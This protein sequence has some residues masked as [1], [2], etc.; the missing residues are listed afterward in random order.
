MLKLQSTIGRAVFAVLAAFAVL[1][2]GCGRALPPSSFA[3]EGPML[4][5][6]RFFGGQTRSTG[7]LETAAGAPSQ[8]FSVQGQGRAL[9]DGRFYLDQTVAFEGKPATTRRW[10]ISAVDAHHYVASLTDAGG[11]VHAQAYGN[12]FHL[13]YPMKGLPLG[14]VEQWL[15]LQPDGCTVMNEAVVRVAGLAVRRLSERISRVDGACAPRAS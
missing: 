5:P 4:R 11:A 14:G 1:L 8:R 7:V 13:T 15:Y 3:S 10:V 6:E 2:C 12:L 9:S